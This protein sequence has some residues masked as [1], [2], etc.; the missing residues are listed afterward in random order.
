MIVRPVDIEPTDPV[1]ELPRQA[2]QSSGWH[3]KERV[4]LVPDQLKSELETGTGGVP[5]EISP[6][7]GVR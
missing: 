2:R 7:T 1:I 5:K 3:P 6:K 4:D